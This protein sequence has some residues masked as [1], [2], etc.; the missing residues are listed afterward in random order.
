MSRQRGLT[1][2]TMARLFLTVALLLVSWPGAVPRAEIQAEQVVVEPAGLALGQ[3][4][5]PGTPTMMLTGEL[6][7]TT[8]VTATGGVGLTGFDGLAVPLNTIEAAPVVTIT[9]PLDGATY[10]EGDSISF[11]G[12]AN[13]AEDGDLTASLAWV[14]DLDGSIG[15]GGSFSDSTL[16]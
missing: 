13:D 11:A 1:W 14:S 2:L 6:R 12:S 16:S 10:N 5:D 9:A 3:V 7:S 4:S 15:T 8:V